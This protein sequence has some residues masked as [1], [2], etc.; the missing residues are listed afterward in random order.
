MGIDE[1]EEADNYINSRKACLLV[2]ITV[3]LTLNNVLKFQSS[4]HNTFL[5]VVNSSSEN[6]FA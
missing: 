4:S 3:M 6:K 2:Q 5:I 1:K